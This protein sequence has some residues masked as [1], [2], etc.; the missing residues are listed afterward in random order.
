MDKWNWVVAE[1]VG[2]HPIKL[3]LTTKFTEKEVK[4]FYNENI[5]WWH[6]VTETRE[7]EVSI[8]ELESVMVVGAASKTAKD[9][10]R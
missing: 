3:I 4:R 5:L 10:R 9:I 8:E 1:K 7:S 6:K 2:I